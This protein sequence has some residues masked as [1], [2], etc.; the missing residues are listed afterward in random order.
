[1]LRYLPVGLS[2]GTTANRVDLWNAKNFAPLEA[3]DVATNKRIRI[4]ILQ[5]KHH[6]LN[7]DTVIRT[8]AGGNVPEGIRRTRRAEG[9]RA[10]CG[11]APRFPCLCLSLGPGLLPGRLFC[12]ASGRSSNLFLHTGFLGVNRRI[13]QNGVFTHQATIGP[14]YFQQKIEIGLP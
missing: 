8:N 12:L 5:S 7:R 2:T 10:L 4:G 14:G 11:S 9:T 6:L 3:I 1:M 13:D